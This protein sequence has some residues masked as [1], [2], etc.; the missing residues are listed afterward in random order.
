MYVGTFLLLFAI[1]L[2]VG[3]LGRVFSVSSPPLTC[4]TAGAHYFGRFHR[5]VTKEGHGADINRGEGSAVYLWYKHGDGKPIVAVEVLYDDEPVPDGF[6]KMSKDLTYGVDKKVYMCYRTQ[7]AGEELSPITE[8]RVLYN[9]DEPEGDD[10][11]DYERVDK[12]LNRKDVHLWFKRRGEG[13]VDDAA[14]SGEMLRVGEYMDCKVCTR[15]CLCASTRNP[16]SFILLYRG[17]P[18][19]L[20]SL[21]RVVRN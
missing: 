18:P 19:P 11:K 2:F 14:W 6:T 21:L 9:E 4:C 15:L 10:G 17:F 5:C 1:F 8:I 7:G 20:F 13:D 16:L 3:F 12:A